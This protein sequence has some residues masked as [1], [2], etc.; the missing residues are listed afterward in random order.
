[1]YSGGCFWGGMG[2]VRPVAGPGKVGIIISLTLNKWPSRVWGGVRSP[3]ALF[4]THSPS[5]GRSPLA[6]R[7]NFRITHLCAIFK[8]TIVNFALV[9][10]P[11]FLLFHFFLYFLYFFF[12][13]FYH[14]GV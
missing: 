8:L 6:L 12:L 3:G 13:L 5:L 14:A 11:A 7:K 10:S 1:M 2:H 4:R 9:A